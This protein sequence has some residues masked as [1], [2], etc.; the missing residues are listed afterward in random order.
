MM[1]VVPQFT[2]KYFAPWM[3]TVKGALVVM[4]LWDAVESGTEDEREDAVA[5]ATLHSWMSLEVSAKFSCDSAKEL[6]S[7]LLKRYNSRSRSAIESIKDR[8]ARISIEDSEIGQYLDE[9]L[10]G[11]AELRERSAGLDEE[12]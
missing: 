10:E 11:I 12:E 3:K 6:W 2:G 7:T 5:I 1:I 8:I 4:D 9:M